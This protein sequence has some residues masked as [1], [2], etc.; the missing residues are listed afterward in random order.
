M[1]T[2]TLTQTQNLINVLNAKFATL[3]NDHKDFSTDQ[4]KFIILAAKLKVGDITN[5]IQ[6]IIR[7]KA[8]FFVDSTTGDIL[9]VARFNS[10]LLGTL[11]NVSDLNC[12]DLFTVNRIGVFLTDSV[13]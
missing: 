12:A 1:T 9:R 10:P 7:D 3:V 8:K 5:Y 4:K 6:V 11:G 2:S 13:L